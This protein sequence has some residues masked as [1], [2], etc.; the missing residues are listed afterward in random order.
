MV[1]DTIETSIASIVEG[2]PQ[3]DE[4]GDVEADDDLQQQTAITLGDLRNLMFADGSFMA[5][6]LE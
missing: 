2:L 1:V 4:D 3:T 6:P 5:A